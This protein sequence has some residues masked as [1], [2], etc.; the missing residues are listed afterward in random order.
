MNGE[1]MNLVAYSETDYR[2]YVHLRSIRTP[3]GWK[4]IENLAK[5]EKAKAYELEQE[6]FKWLGSMDSDPAYYGDKKELK[7][8]G[9]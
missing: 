3:D 7:I 9:Y 4:L 2:Q 8:K 5:K 6:L 1:Q